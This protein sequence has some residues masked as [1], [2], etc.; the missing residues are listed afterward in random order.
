MVNS[1]MKFI[2]MTRGITT[3]HFNCKKCLKN[4]QLSVPIMHNMLTVI[5]FHGVMLSVVAPWVEYLMNPTV[6]LTPKL[7]RYIVFSVQNTLAYYEFY[8]IDT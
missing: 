3:L 7:S 2:I 1:I 4:A 5:K 6:W 8:D